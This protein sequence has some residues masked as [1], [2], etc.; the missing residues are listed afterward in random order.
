[1]SFE[2]VASPPIEK[3]RSISE[4]WSVANQ[5]YLT[6]A[7]SAVRSWLTHLVDPQAPATVGVELDALAAEMVAPPALETLC[8]TFGL[9]PFERDLLLLCAGVEL[10]D[11]LRQM[12]A[13]A[14]GSDA[15]PGP[16][17]A[18]ALAA[19]PGAHWSAQAPN[20]P[21]RYW[22]LVDLRG[23]DA[24][25]RAL[26]R[27]DE[28][29]L[30]Y[31][32]GI[33]HLDDRLVGLVEP[34]TLQGAFAPSHAVLANEI[35]QLWT[36]SG[37]RLP[38]VQLC[39]TDRAEQRAIAAEVCRKLGITLYLLPVA[40]IPEESRE[41]DA[42]LRLW[43]REA[44]LSQAAL[45]IDC[46]EE[47]GELAG[48]TQLRRLIEKLSGLIFLS[49]RQPLSGV[50]RTVMT[51]PV[52]R[53]TPTEQAACWRAELGDRAASL[54][55]QVDQLVSQFN[56]G[57]PAIAAT[58]EGFANDPSVD[59]ATGG[60]RL[61]DLCRVQNRPQLDD[62]AQRINVQAAW[63]DLV[64]PEAQFYTLRTLV[65]QVRQRATVYET[66]GFAAKSARGLGISALFAGSSGTGKTLA[67]EVLA[68]ALRLDLYR[69]DLSQVV[70]KY[71]GETEKN[72]G[73]VFD[74]ADGGGMVLL[75]DEADALF[76]K[77]S[78]VKDSHDRYANIEV[79]YLLQRMES[80]RGLAILT[81]NLK[82]S[83]D[84]AFLR[85][86]RFI[87]HFPFPDVNQRALIWQRIFPAEAPLD[88]LDY[89]KLARLN[90]AGGSIRN[91]A[92][93]GAF[94]AADA[95]ESLGMRHL[96]HAAQIE[97]SKLERTLSER[98]VIDWD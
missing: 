68:Q 45:L 7:L 32:V 4:S 49:R 24:P 20:A 82:E 79:S 84:T 29:I 88:A 18:L 28:R 61:W 13:E 66:W 81:T 80:Y 41:L 17:F 39:G 2:D 15:A 5:R 9:T 31:L 90:V 70:S 23:D 83:L 42:L 43:E 22:R 35:V 44:A 30:H 76:G 85:R 54:N 91:I 3:E 33:Y 47:A 21:L 72:L 78:E 92:L 96:R 58:V 93:N 57:L 55:G 25:T 40:A 46:H 67:A 97:F 26:L 11:E 51:Y 36:G 50:I 53:P 94:L 16:T 52:M 60:A 75:F 34:I 74:A 8:V 62:L 87:V 6:A 95:G 1:M 98:D 19:L 86:I 71:I 73:R 63:D 56:L 77:R 48:T 37:V 12:V 10:D 59:T 38:A 89:A 64:L 69:I 14:A 27:I 65:A